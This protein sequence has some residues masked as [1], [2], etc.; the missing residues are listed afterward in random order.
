MAFQSAAAAVA[1][2]PRVAAWLPRLRMILGQTDILLGLGVI[3]ILVVLILPLPGFL[4]DLLLALS[5][6]FSVLI[7]LTAL[8]IERPLEFNAF[9]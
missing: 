3:A 8:F 7:L 4:L 1:A 9:P 5:I 2:S 6:T